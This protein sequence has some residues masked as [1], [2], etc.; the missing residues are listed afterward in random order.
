MMRLYEANDSL[1][2][3]FNQQFEMERE[4]IQIDQDY[5]LNGVEADKMFESN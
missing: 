4:Y 1:N 2:V 3:L 5:A